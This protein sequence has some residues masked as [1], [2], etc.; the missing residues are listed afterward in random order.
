MENRCE[1]IHEYEG[2]LVVATL[3]PGGKTYKHRKGGRGNKSLMRGRGS[4]RCYE[5]TNERTGA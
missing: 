5:T 4:W 1:R 3:L 2:L